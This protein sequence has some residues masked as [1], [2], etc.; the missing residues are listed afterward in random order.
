MHAIGIVLDVNEVDAATQENIILEVYKDI[1]TK[2]QF[3]HI[4]D[5]DFSDFLQASSANTQSAVI[6]G[7]ALHF[8][9]RNPAD[10]LTGGDQGKLLG[11]DYARDSNSYP[12]NKYWM[13][14]LTESSDQAAACSSLVA[15][16]QSPDNVARVCGKHLKLYDGPDAY[17]FKVEPETDKPVVAKPSF[18]KRRPFVSTLLIGLPSIAA[19]T[20]AFIALC[21]LVPPVGALAT[22]GMMGLIIASKFYL[23]SAAISGFMFANASIMLPIVLGG[24][25]ALG[26]SV[27]TGFAALFN[28]VKRHFPTGNAGAYMQQTIDADELLTRVPEPDS[29]FA[30]RRAMTITQPEDCPWLMAP[31]AW[32]EAGVDGEE[33]MQPVAA[34]AE[35]QD[36]DAEPDDELFQTARASL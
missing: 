23:A 21:I 4:S 20:I 28:Y 10:K 6:Q 26:L 11:A 29:H 34:P 32:K 5:I 27:N 8:S 16:L 25:L 31:R 36:K 7:T 3:K 14:T 15:R 33:E 13:G 2:H 24:V 1:L 35:Q 19:L 9:R 22:G 17:A 30:M 18:L 12:G